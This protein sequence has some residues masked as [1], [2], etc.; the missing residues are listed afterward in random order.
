MERYPL[1]SSTKILI[2]ETVV[3]DGLQFL[4]IE[5]DAAVAC[6]ADHTLAVPGHRGSQR[7]G[8]VMSHGRRS[9]IGNQPLIHLQLRH[10]IRNNTGS[11]VPAHHYVV[12]S[13]ALEQLLHKV[14]RAERADRVSC[15]WR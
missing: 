9:G 5:H 3:H 10:L 7:G 1:L 2:G 6:E 11:G 13:Q 15:V 12:V 8:K 4:N 14:I